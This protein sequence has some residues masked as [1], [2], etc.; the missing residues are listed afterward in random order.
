[1]IDEIFGDDINVTKKFND[2]IR[3]LKFLEK[4]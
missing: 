3:M 1:M 2:N 4:N